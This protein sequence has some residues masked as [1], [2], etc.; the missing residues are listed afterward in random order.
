[1]KLVVG[2]G[3]PGRKYEGTRHNVG[4][5]VVDELSR[6]WQIE[7]TRRRFNGLCGGGRVGAESVTL[8]K[9]QTFMNLSG[10]SVREVVAFHK[11]ERTDLIVVLD[12]LALPLGKLRLRPRGSAGGHNGL[13]S[14]IAEL[15]DDGFARLRLGIEWV[16]SRQAVGHVLGTFSDEEVPAVEKMILRAADAVTCWLTRG[17]DAAMNEYN[18][19]EADSEEP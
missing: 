18:K 12:D 1:M 14:V 17:I 8:L 5:G 10:R 2:L 11:L 3:N 7:V 19:S 4:F 16:E 15:G 13:T 9:P 6:R